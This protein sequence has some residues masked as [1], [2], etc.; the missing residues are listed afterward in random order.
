VLNKFTPVGAP[1]EEI[2]QAGQ[3]FS[4][5]V[6]ADSG[7]RGFRR[8]VRGSVAQTVLRDA[9]HSVMIVR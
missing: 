5:I 8:F 2:I 6:L 1:A 4:V 7:K 9:H 3:D